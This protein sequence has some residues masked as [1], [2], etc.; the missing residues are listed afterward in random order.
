MLWSLQREQ[1]L[2]WSDLVLPSSIIHVKSG[3]CQKSLVRSSG[4]IQVGGDLLS[5]ILEHA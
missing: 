2:A 1:L 4:G 3:S 5:F